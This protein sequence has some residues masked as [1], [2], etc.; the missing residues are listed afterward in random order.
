MKPRHEIEASRQQLIGA[1]RAQCRANAP[2]AAL[3]PVRELAQQFKLSRSL[4]GEVVQSL[5]AEGILQAR[6]GA[7][8]FVN[9]P[10]QGKSGLFL[11]I[12]PANLSENTKQLLPMKLGFE[13]RVTQI[14]GTSLTL[15]YEQVHDFLAQS[16]GLNIEGVFNF[17]DEARCPEYSEEIPSPIPQVTLGRLGEQGA[18]GGTSANRDWIA[19][20]HE[21]SGYQATR[22][23]LDLGHQHIAF[24]GLRS[25]FEPKTVLTWSTERQHGWKRALAEQGYG[26]EMLAFNPEEGRVLSIAEQVEAARQIAKKMIP[27][28]RQGRI[29]SL[30]AVNCHAARGFFQALSAAGVSHEQWPAVICFGAAE[31][32]GDALS[33]MTEMRMPWEELGR[34][35]ANLLRSRRGYTGQ[36]RQVLVPLRLVSRLSCK[37]NWPIFP[38]S[39]TVALQHI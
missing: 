33:V 37:A 34:E 6:Q 21:D 28:V 16:S 17:V 10:P 4:V 20:D 7:G 26:A 18:P 8:I 1:L 36:P 2:G 30:V 23:L 12:G 39:V 22:H 19:F 35:A 3:S 25:P 5:A 38:Q 11:L 27:L 31:S 29:S 32:T 15:A 14:G 13:E 9:R 24:L